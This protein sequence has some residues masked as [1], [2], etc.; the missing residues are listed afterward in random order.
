M[1][2]RQEPVQSKI[3]SGGN[4]GKFL[5]FAFGSNLLR[6]RLHI[7]NP[8]AVFKAVA[9]LPAHRLEFNYFSK[10]WQGAAATVVE[11]DDEEV[12][13]VLWELNLEHLATLDAQEGVPTVYNRKAV[14]VE[15][16]AGEEEAFTYFLVKPVEEDR[17][18]SAVYLDV[19][20]RGAKENGLPKEY[21]EKLKSIED[22]GYCGEVGLTI[23]LRERTKIPD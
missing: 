7:S 20:V 15:T 12:W 22:N 3:M 18:P 2:S 6:E 11:V 21:I 17:R 4:G 16:E 8:S 10:R 14:T 9:R 23:D 1:G 19:I 5:Y 13:G